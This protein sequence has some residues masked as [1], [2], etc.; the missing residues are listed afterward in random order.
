MWAVCRH[1][2]ASQLEC[3]G[4]A[5][6]K[7]HW[8]ATR[9]AAAPLRGCREPRWS[10]HPVRRLEPALGHVDRFLQ[11]GRHVQD[12]L[13]LLPELLP[14][15]VVQLLRPRDGVPRLQVVPVQEG[16]QHLPRRQEQ[17][18]RQ[19]EGEQN[20]AQG[21]VVQDLLL[22]GLQQLPPRLEHGPQLASILRRLRAMGA[23]RPEGPAAEDEQRDD[24]RVGRHEDEREEEEVEV[25]AHHG[26]L[27]P[28][29]EGAAAAPTHHALHHGEGR[30]LGEGR[31]PVVC[32][33]CQTRVDDGAPQADEEEDPL[34]RAEADELEGQHEEHR[35]EEREGVAV[36][37]G[38]LGRQLRQHRRHPLR[39]LPPE[40]I[41]PRSHDEPPHGE[42]AEDGELDTWGKPPDPD[43]LE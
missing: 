15:L 10:A 17:A 30:A 8:P 6:A 29:L 40:G 3:D 37:G 4:E 26:L 2:P 9:A 20:L 11:E 16:C 22:P 36:E 13:H 21:A 31:R 23:H 41:E 32:L 27:Q 1:G 35:G 19:P 33:Q 42:D 43:E 7:K 12:R 25:H 18:G 28:S 34:H 14:S 24:R 39:D 5:A 38:L